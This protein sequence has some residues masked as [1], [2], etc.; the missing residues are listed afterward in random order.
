[1]ARNFQN[2][3][4]EELSLIIT[5]ADFAELTSADLSALEKAAKEAGILTEQYA[6]IIGL[7]SNNKVYEE[8]KNDKNSSEEDKAVALAAR[9]EYNRNLRQRM[10]NKYY[11]AEE[12]LSMAVVQNGKYF[13]PDKIT[14]GEMDF[15]VESGALRW[16]DFG[17]SK[18][19]KVGQ[20]KES[21]LESIKKTIAQDA[22]KRALL[23]QLL[24]PLAENA[25]KREAVAA[26]AKKAET[27]SL[28]ADLQ[29]SYDFWNKFNEKSEETGV[30][31]DIENVSNRS[32]I[33]EAKKDGKTMFK[34][35]DH[36]TKGFDIVKRDKSAEPYEI[37]DLLVKKAKASNPKTKIR[38]KDNVKDEVLR[39]KILIAC[40]KN[41]MMPVGNLPEGFDFEELKALVKDAKTTEDINDLAVNLYQP[42]EF[43]IGAERAEEN[44]RDTIVPVV[45]PTYKIKEQEEKQTV[46]VPV[47]N[48]TGK[49]DGKRGGAAVA[50]IV[51]SNG[52]GGSNVPP[53][54]K[55]KKKKKS[56]GALSRF[57]NKAKVWVM[58]GV[59]AAAGLF[60][61]KSCQ[62]NQ[63]K[64]ADKIEQISKKSLSDCD[65]VQALIDEKYDD[66]YDAGYEAGKK[67]CESSKP[68]PVVKKKTV[69][70]KKKVTPVKPAPVFLPGDTIKGD[71]I[72]VPGDTIKGKP[73]YVPG[74]TIK[75]E[76]VILAADTIPAKPVPAKQPKA[77]PSSVPLTEIDGSIKHEK[78]YDLNDARD[79]EANG[80][81][82]ASKKKEPEKSKDTVLNFMDLYSLTQNQKQH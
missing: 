76:P 10:T 68:K 2:M 23:A 73:V 50:P 13:F 56:G 80:K 21:N 64:M 14:K 15:L 78:D 66:G 82:A 3:T 69:P 79:L 57:W 16:S 45:L 72:I 61:V 31:F 11:N 6:N 17:A 46:V 19:Y 55:D 4:K 26:Q 35:I 9:N 58:A 25:A 7:A 59:V 20:E 32:L 39:N 49:E 41:N 1:M 53:A 12:I 40:A 52:N 24:P 37:F 63:D 60:G 36:G 75:G 43:G 67:D 28:P 47:Q 42:Q 8:I 34:G 71:P 33:V 62:N 48:K 30:K 5:E 51:A 18:D 44:A 27:S 74:D 22:E 65:A 81:T 38:I 54:N 29:K 77:N 70:V